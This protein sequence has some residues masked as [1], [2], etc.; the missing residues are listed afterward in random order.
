MIIKSLL[1]FL[2]KFIFNFL[3]DNEDKMPSRFSKAIA[4]YYPDARIRKIYLKKLGIIM[5][6]NTYSNPGLIHASDGSNKP[7][8]FIGNN[9]TIAPGLTVISDACPINSQLL[10]NLEYVKTKLIKTGPIIIEDDVWIGANVTIF[11]GV[12]IKKGCVIG[13]GAV[14]LHDTEPYST[15]AGVPAKL[16]HNIGKEI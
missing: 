7:A 15:Y 14:V 9:V 13:A 8:V 1:E 10:Q 5:G 3:E 2:D 11:P 6:E 4:Y 12:T 16:L